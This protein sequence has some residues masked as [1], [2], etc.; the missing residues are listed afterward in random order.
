M[1]PAGPSAPSGLRRDLLV[2]LGLVAATLAVYAQA[3][4]FGF[5]DYD[6]FFLI[7]Q[8][9]L[10]RAGVT[11][12]GLLWALQTSYFDFWHP[13]TWWSQMLDCQLFGVNPG[14]HHLVN[15]AFHAA[16]TVLVYLV[17]QRFTGAWKRSAMVAA[18][19]ALHPMH[20]ESVAWLAERKDV[21]SAFF[22]LLALASYGG[23]AK[24]S[25]AGDPRARWFFLLVFFCFAL[26]LMSKSMVVTFPFALLLLDY[27]PLR[28]GAN[29]R[30]LVV[31]KIPLFIL[32]FVS[33]AITYAGMKGN[34]NVLSGETVPWGLR[35]ASL[36]VSYLEYLGKLFWPVNLTIFY[37]R[38]EHL[39]YGLVA[40][41]LAT[42]LAITGLAVLG[43]R[44][45][46]WL[47]CGWLW[48]L[49]MLVPVIGLVSMSN[50]AI[51]DRYTY[52]P[53][54]GLFVA[55]VWLVADGVAGV[56]FR[57][58]WLPVAAAGLLAVCGRVA[59]KQT[60]VWRNGATLWSHSLAVGPVNVTTEYNLGWA[61]QHSGEPEKGMDCYRA[62][63]RLQ[64]GHLD[65]NL[66]LGAALL[67]LG[68]DREAVEY[69]NRVLQLNPAYAR[70]Q[71]NLGRALFE[72]GDLA[73]AVQHS[74]A[75]VR[76]DPQAFK[77]VFWLVKALGSGPQPDEVMRDFAGRLEASP[78]DAETW[79]AL[80]MEWLK[81]GKDAPAE[82]SF[83]FAVQQNP[84][85][86]AARFQL[87]LLLRK[88]GAVGEAIAQYQTLLKLYPDQSLALNNLAWIRAT[89][90]QA[91][92][93][94]GAEAVRL[95]GRACEL[96]A[97]R[98]IVFLGTLAA[99][100]AEA[101]QFDRAVQAAQ[102]ACDLA[103]AQGQTNLL[104]LNQQ[105]LRQ[106]QRHQ[107]YREPE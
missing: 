2:C 18:L 83:N 30:G 7:S 51:S 9:P 88:T 15:V 70:A 85:S 42:L 89:H 17:L 50:T 54:I 64:P 28:R 60:G 67:D 23:Y 87:A 107:P 76:L 34:Q 16:N 65:A 21:L 61:F 103:G 44:R 25:A 68:R 1:N 86:A 94:N 20:V 99:A 78:L 96:T 80:G 63:L 5:S 8:N 4:R 48:F 11:W 82:A 39:A 59:W 55:V 58:R 81:R 53:S 97:N 32:S 106:Y 45:S 52:L 35:L 71:E 37:P 6:D 27:W 13:L 46:P 102:N 47:L 92:W 93:R 66:N 36:P 26:A 19:F 62:V 3:G 90:P 41:A 14:W 31:E 49:G 10:V 77:A 101:G 73:G 79:S 69:F 40:L 75:A 24:R 29:W 57:N 98:E 84:A 12:P 104:E 43:W 38:P 22:F 33:C 95:A 74:E 100:C 91:Q 72:L 105:L 56:P